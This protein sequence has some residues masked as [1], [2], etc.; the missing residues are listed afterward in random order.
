MREKHITVGFH[1]QN[2]SSHR[3]L[4]AFKILFKKSESRDNTKFQKMVVRCLE[5]HCRREA[6]K[7]HSDNWE[8]SSID[9]LWYKMEIDF[10]LKVGADSRDSSS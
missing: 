8:E 7:K 9:D 1:G 10:S 5:L 3:C 4:R 2:S 6:N